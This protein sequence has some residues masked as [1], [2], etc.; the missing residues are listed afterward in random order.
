MKKGLIP[1]DFIDQ[2][3]TSTDIVDIIGKAIPLKKRGINL[4]ACCPFHDEKTPSFYVSP[5]KQ[6]YHCFG[7][8]AGGN[9]IGFLKEYENLNFVETIEE[10]A[11]LQGLEVPRE[12]TPNFNP[13][14]QKKTK[15]QQTLIYE[16]LDKANKLYQWQLRKDKDAKKIIDYIKSRKLSA[17]TVK[18]FALGFASDNWRNLLQTLSSQY[19]LNDLINAGLII[20]NNGQTYDKFRNRLIFPIKNRQGKVIGF[21]GRA[22]EKEQQPKYLNS[23]ETPVFH[24][25]NEIYGLYEIRK[26][27]ISLDYLLVT[28]GY[29]DVIGLYEHGFKKAIAT[30]GT[31]LT[32][33]HIKRLFRETNKLVFCFDSDSAGKQAAIRALHLILPF[34]KEEKEA[35]F[36]S[37]PDNE[38]PDSFIQKNKLEVFEEKIKNA[39]SALDFGLEAL[40]H[41]INFEKADDKARLIEQSTHLISLMNPAYE[42]MFVHTLSEKLKISPQQ[43]NNLI[44]FYKKKNNT[45]KKQTQKSTHFKPLQ[46]KK[47]QLALEEKAIALLIQHPKAALHLPT[48]ELAKTEN[49]S[50]DN[51]LIDT[52][53]LAKATEHTGLLFEHLQ[54]QY[55]SESNY[56]FSLSSIDFSLLSENEAFSE[57][58]AIFIKL[59][60]KNDDIILNK[61]IEKT[62]YAAL[63]TTEKAQMKRLLQRN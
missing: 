1:Q 7:C 54:E 5:Q 6:I 57:L 24:K 12:N 58:N 10:L 44:S 2:I 19:K 36:L 8:G 52:L 34:L 31:A 47:D 41:Q 38:D 62:K 25:G 20:Q 61:L 48:I 27:R 18:I 49:H 53:D 35:F 32:E 43:L 63:T 3:I 50:K 13:E 60:Q 4:T 33:Q 16:I 55:P 17:Q 26:S 46:L 15:D 14:A 22:I 45:A 39:T 28:E 9:V 56:L 42:T 11:S 40:T 21:G 51:L 59:K 37:L 29:M 30:L 23:P